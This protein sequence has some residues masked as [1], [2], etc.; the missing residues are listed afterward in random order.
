MK[1]HMFISFQNKPVYNST[2]MFIYYSKRNCMRIEIERER[3]RERTILNTYEAY[4]SM[5]PLNY[6]ELINK[7]H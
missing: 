1:C 2:N 7:T 3:E 6:F 5:N 4:S